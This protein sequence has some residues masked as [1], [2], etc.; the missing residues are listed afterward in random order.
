MDD[1]KQDAGGGEGIRRLTVLEFNTVFA[2]NEKHTEGKQFIFF[3]DD[4][5]HKM[6]KT[7]YT[8]KMFNRF[9]TGYV[10]ALGLN[11]MDLETACKE[12]RGDEWLERNIPGRSGDFDCRYGEP[13]AEGKKYL[14]PMVKAELDF[15]EWLAS[16][17]G[18][19]PASSRPAAREYEPPLESYANMS[20]PP[21]G[22]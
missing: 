15:Q 14:A 7:L 1:Y 13:N 12:G 2:K 6:Y 3:R 10:I 8:S 19:A 16:Q 11:P 21:D 9:L 18:N 17:N 22:Y 20:P 5:E 4:P